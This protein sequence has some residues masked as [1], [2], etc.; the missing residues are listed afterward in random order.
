MVGFRTG[1][2]QSMDGSRV[3]E[4]HK[5][6]GGLCRVSRNFGLNIVSKEYQIPSCPS[7]PGVTQPKT[8]LLAVGCTIR[9][10]PISHGKGYIGD[11]RIANGEHQG[12]GALYTSPVL[13]RHMRRFNWVLVAV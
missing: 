4:G 13:R 6:P 5:P 9:S 2:N 8:G 11:G 12:S 3:D 7:A 10:A 1:F